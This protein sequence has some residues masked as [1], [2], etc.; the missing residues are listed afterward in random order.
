MHLRLA[1]E[2]AKGGPARKEAKMDPPDRTNTQM[3]LRQHNMEVLKALPGV[4]RPSKMG[5]SARN[6]IEYA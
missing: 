5:N 3:D 2:A 4:F 6:A 1:S